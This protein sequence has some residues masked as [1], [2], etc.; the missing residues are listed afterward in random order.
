MR[1]VE[2][3]PISRRADG[4]QINITKIVYGGDKP[5]ILIA[6]VVHGD[7]LTSLYTIWRLLD[8]LDHTKIKGTVTIIPVINVDGVLMGDRFEPYNQIDI[9]RVYPGDKRGI[10]AERV[11]WEIYS[12]AL[13]HDIVIDLHCAG[14]SIPFILIDPIDDSK[15]RETVLKYAESVG[16]TIVF[17][18]A[19]N[20]YELK[21]LSKS[22]PAVVL[23]RGIPSFTMELPGGKQIDRI[24][25]EAGFRGLVNLLIELGVCKGRKMLHE[26]YPVISDYSLYRHDITCTNGGILDLNFELGDWIEKGVEIAVIRGF[27]GKIIE[28]IYCDKQG[29]LI[30]LPSSDMIPPHGRV[31]TIAVKE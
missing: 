19:K 8:F 6:A 26:G 4:S 3:I 11:A 27:T 21:G 10:L 1:R 2:L 17:E 15:L 24:G 30:S 7:E 29:Y 18:Y 23:K 20:I 5:S 31:S 22:L 25:G 12:I 14:R 28:R 13:H 16:L 9:N